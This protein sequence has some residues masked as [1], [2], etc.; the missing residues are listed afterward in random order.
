MPFSPEQKRLSTEEI[1]RILKVGAQLGIS[2]IR[3]TGGEPLVRKDI[4]LLVDAATKIEGIRS[5]HLTTNGL[6]LDKHLENFKH[7]G[8]TGLN[9]SL[10]SLEATRF[11]KITRRNGLAKVLGN[12]YKAIEIGIPKIKL[13]VVALKNFNTDELYRFVEIT[14]NHPVTVRFIELMPF[15]SQENTWREATYTS[16]V[17]IQKLL[18]T[19]YPELQVEQGTAT[20]KLSF[21]LPGYK[22]SFA[23]IPAYT[24]SLCEACTRLRITADGKLMNC[25]YSTEKSYN[26]RELMRTGATDN[27]IAEYFRL[28]VQDKPLNGIEAQSNRNFKH[29]C[30]T[31]IGG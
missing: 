10:D 4:D 30:M 7:S 20:E 31:Q 19:A 28:S 21:S 2:K 26:L 14:K 18:K 11:F 13:N 22:G 6:L 15:N 29:D 27:D 1:L 3:F 5:V 9:I 17:Y 16:A 8:L 23:I 24:R 12:I 25:L